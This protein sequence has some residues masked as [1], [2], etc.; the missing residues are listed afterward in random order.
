MYASS[1]LI[2][3]RRSLLA[4]ASNDFSL[5]FDSRGT[6][7]AA[8]TPM[9]T[10]TIRSSIS[11]KPRVVSGTV[12]MLANAFYLAAAWQGPLSV[13]VTLS[14][15]YPASTVLLARFVL[16]ERL[17]ARQWIGVACA[18]VAVTVIVQ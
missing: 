17:S 18:L 6:A 5:V 8:R 10:T 14:S 4:A 1:A 11:E 7:I 15:L 2:A 12:D 13:V 16:H 9:I 3:F